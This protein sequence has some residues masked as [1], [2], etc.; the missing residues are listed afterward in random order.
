MS[1]PWTRLPARAK[2]LP[3]LWSLPAVR[4]AALSST[5]V[6]VFFS[7]PF[8]LALGLI[9]FLIFTYF[10]L[11]SKWLSLVSLAFLV[12]VPLLLYF[13]YQGISEELVV[14]V[15]FLL[16]III[17]LEVKS[18]LFENILTLK[19][20]PKTEFSFEEHKL[21]PVKNSVSAL[22]AASSGSQNSPQNPA[23]PSFWDVQKK[24]LTNYK[25]RIVAWHLWVVGSFGTLCL[26]LFNF[27]GLPYFREITSL[28]F[29]FQPGQSGIDLSFFERS[30]HNELV[31][32][33]FGAEFITRTFYRLTFFGGLLLTYYF[34]L[35][36]QDLFWED[37][38]Q[39]YA[40]VNQVSVYF[41][42]LFFVFN[43]WTYER[44]LTGDLATLR[45]HLFFIPVLFY[46][47]RY[48]RTF[49]PA[50]GRL[51]EEYLRYFARFSWALLLLSLVSPTHVFFVLGL[52]GVSLSVIFCRHVILYKKHN[53]PAAYIHR[54]VKLFSLTL[55]ILTP[56]FFILFNPVT[57]PSQKQPVNLFSYLQ[58]NP[59][60]R[61]FVTTA[62]SLQPGLTNESL[63]PNAF[64]GGSAW[65]SPQLDEIEAGKNLLGGW[66][67]LSYYHNAGLGWFFALASGLFFLVLNLRADRR[68]Y[69]LV[70]IFLAFLP[71][72]LLLSF[73]YASSGVHLVNQ[74]FYG[75][76]FGSLFLD[77]GR[78]YSL[79]LSLAL[80]LT[81]LYCGQGRRRVGRVFL[82]LLG[83]GVLSN[84]L[85]FLPLTRT[86]SSLAYPVQTV[87]TV[88]Q[89]CEEQN[90]HVLFYP[91]EARV[92]LPQSEVFSRYAYHHFTPC[93]TLVPNEVILDLPTGETR[94]LARDDVTARIHEATRR[95]LTSP[96]DVSDYE[97]Y[98]QILRQNKVGVLV[99]ETA[100]SLEAQQ[101]RMY[102][103]EYLLDENEGQS[104]AVFTII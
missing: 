69:S 55:L 102:L 73:G 84:L 81:V 65:L 16:L 45:G 42:S 39:L 40:R 95:Y 5:V 91:F 26:L 36:L 96:N 59:T 12:A 66:S 74:L 62:F 88:R 98:R 78:F 70:G 49:L 33:G 80:L 71:V 51:G 52:L 92:R 17:A 82:G 79:F 77:T 103:N 47:L 63:L 60:D 31:N 9:I 21:L 22:P 14:Y 90:E 97:S 53:T 46:L 99:V 87:Q 57:T 94:T 3:E 43:P 4:L 34:T 11:S 6:I 44:F 67:K 7:L 64:L 23:K 75:L 28:P 30:V 100:H 54:Y 104:S 41:L 32:A 83:A 93:P 2:F 35:R 29:Y 58:N 20:A 37:K 19:Q 27:Q 25:V 89:V 15:Y 24:L 1:K 101:L 8:G 85:L 38:R 56:T 10:R 72:S 13:G 86:L 18:Y 76:P 50:W 48:V 61:V 68:R